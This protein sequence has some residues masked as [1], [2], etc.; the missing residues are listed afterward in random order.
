MLF[1]TAN[2]SIDT[3][4]NDSLKEKN[5]NLSVLRL[6]RI[7]P[8]LSGNKLFKLHYFLKE[9][10]SLSLP[11]IFTFGGAYSNHL[12]ATAYACKITGLKSIGFVRG[13]KPG[14]LSQTLIA[15]INY[16]MQLH[17]IPRATYD[18]KER[19][20]FLNDLK[21][22]ERQYLMIPEGGYHPKGAAGAALITRFIDENTTH[23]CT[24]LGTAATI[25]GIIAGA[26]E[27]QQVVGIPVLKGMT[28]IT[29]RIA[30][31]TGGH[32]NFQLLEDYHFGGYAKR[33]LQ[34]TSFMNQ[35]YRQYQL[36]TD[37]V[38]TAK[39]MFAVLDSLKKGYF[40]PGS[41]ITCLHTGGLQGN[42]SLPVGTLIF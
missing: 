16:G 4:L 24:A 39:M 32:R 15:C 36:P 18:K 2:I 11:G 40:A 14:K 7:H 21:N 25:A 20:Y 41:K 35:L 34:L 6:D 3:I 23:I 1:N 26:K 10:I 37:F 38:Y 31:L 27:S 9:A 28:D 30:Y 33:T 42:L 8:I 13:E 17:F 22:E 29:D 5:I 12:V 19:E